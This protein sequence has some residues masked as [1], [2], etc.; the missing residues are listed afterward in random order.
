VRNDE[1]AEQVRDLAR[2]VARLESAAPKSGPRAL[3]P[4]LLERLAGAEGPDTVSYH[5]VGRWGEDTLV[6]QRRH[7]WGE[8]RDRADDGVARVLAALGNAV[9]LR[10]VAVLLAGPAMTA[11]LTER[12]A[13]PSTGQL[14]HHLR[15]LIT[16]GL[17]HQPVRGTYALRR[18]DVIPLLAVFAAST[19]LAVS[20]G[21]QEPA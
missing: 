16:A 17:V 15:E 14:F 8:V 19:D 6:W 18:Q 2:R 9:R 20:G 12:L 3:E 5:G 4:E 10:I 7:E 1:L 13:Q 11:E 21:V